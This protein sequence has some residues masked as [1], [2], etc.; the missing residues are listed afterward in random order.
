MI[1][2]QNVVPIVSTKVDAA[3][4]TVID[5]VS[6]KLSTAELSALNQ[7]SVSEQAAAS[8][9]AKDWLTAQGLWSEEE[10]SAWKDECAALVDEEINAYLNTP[11]QPVEAMFDYLYAELPEELQAQRAQAMAGEKR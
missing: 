2:P 8:V 3:A 7:R 4:A 10:E 9:I 1:L 11:V 6:A 5:G